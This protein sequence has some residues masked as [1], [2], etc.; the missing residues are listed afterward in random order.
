MFRVKTQPA[1]GY[2][3]EDIAMP[4]SAV[5]QLSQRAGGV[6]WLY[7]WCDGTTTKRPLQGTFEELIKQFDEAK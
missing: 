1:D 3:G 7:Y 4:V 6:V 2:D 5:Q